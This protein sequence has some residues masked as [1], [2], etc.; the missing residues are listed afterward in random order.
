MAARGPSR[1][2]KT[3]SGRPFASGEH[4]ARCRPTVLEEPLETEK[5][6]LYEIPAD[7]RA[8]DRREKANCLQREFDGE[9]SAAKPW[10]RGH[11]P[12]ALKRRRDVSVR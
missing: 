6:R 11:V 4:P 10:E 3:P 5:G 2:S 8:E 1:M 7:Q 12:Q 9:M